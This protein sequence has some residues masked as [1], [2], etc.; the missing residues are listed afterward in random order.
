MEG[1]GI[2]LSLNKES[3]KNHMYFFT[4]IKGIKT[5]FNQEQIDLIKD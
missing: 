1:S 3:R 4:Y 2:Y 5:S